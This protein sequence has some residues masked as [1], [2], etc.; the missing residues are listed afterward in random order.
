MMRYTDG[1]NDFNRNPSAFDPIR[2]DFSRG[3]NGRTNNEG[4]KLSKTFIDFLKVYSRSQ[5]KRIFRSGEGSVQNTVPAVQKGFPNGT[6]VAPSPAEQATY[7]EPNQSTV[8]RMDAPMLLLGNVETN[9]ILQK[10]L[11]E[12]G[13]GKQLEHFMKKR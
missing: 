11:C 8:L 13:M 5:N 2:W 12:D 7:S 9:C 3:S 1:P 4:G 10:L 6:N